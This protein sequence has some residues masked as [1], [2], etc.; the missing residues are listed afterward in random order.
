MCLLIGKK[1]KR[2]LKR[3]EK[4]GVLWMNSR[5]EVFSIKSLYSVLEL[6][7]VRYQLWI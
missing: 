5:N 3:E 2:F 4:D 1:K 7:K 6:A